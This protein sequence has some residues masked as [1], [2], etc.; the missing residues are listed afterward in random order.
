MQQNRIGVAE[1]G[2]EVREADRAIKDM[3]G[4]VSG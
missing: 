2:G 1:Q 3:D 4:K